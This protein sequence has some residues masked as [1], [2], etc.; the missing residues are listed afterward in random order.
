MNG[1]GLVLLSQWLWICSRNAPRVE[2]TLRRSRG[3]AGRTDGTG[4]GGL[5]PG[6]LGGAPGLLS[7]SSSVVR[8]RPEA[9]CCGDGWRGPRGSSEG[10]TVSVALHLRRPVGG[11]QRLLT[12]LVG[13]AP[14]SA[15]LWETR[16]GRG[17]SRL[18]AKGLERQMV[19]LTRHQG[20][21]RALAGPCSPRRLSTGRAVRV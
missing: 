13:R 16:G 5:V 10:R 4:S 6:E 15:S 8:G 18:G 11:A 7:L 14:P 3:G 19:G 20:L 17:L 12:S 9:G 21:R 1:Q 2:W